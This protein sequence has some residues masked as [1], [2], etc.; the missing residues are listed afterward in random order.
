MRPDVWITQDNF[1]TLEECDQIAQIIIDHEESVLAIES[2]EDSNFW[3]P[4]TGLTGKYFDYNWLPLLVANGIDI[5]SKIYSV[6]ELQQYDSLWIQCWANMFRQGEGI[7]M[8]NHADDTV[9]EEAYY[10]S[11]DDFYSTHVFL[12]GNPQTGTYYKHLNKT[13]ESVRGQMHLFDPWKEHKVVLNTYAT[14]RISLA[15]DIWYVDRKIP[16]ETKYRVNK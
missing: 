9:P 1:F 11:A 15:M 7:A 5:Q 6:P 2:P 3:T 14:P 13:V 10:G 16:Y 12:A 8:H 4:Y